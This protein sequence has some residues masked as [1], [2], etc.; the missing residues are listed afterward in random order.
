MIDEAVRDTKGGVIVD[1][2]VV[3]NAK[4]HGC[5][6][7]EWRHR[8][9]LRITAKAQKGRANDEI[10]SLLS[11]AGGASIVSGMHNKEKSVFIAASREEVIAFF[12]T[13]I[14]HK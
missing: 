13:L 11:K 4:A 3:P 9:K 5:S 7:D 6:W 1:I 8:I 10:V 2:E 14:D 12:Q